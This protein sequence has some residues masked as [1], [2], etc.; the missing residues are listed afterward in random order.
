MFIYYSAII[1][2]AVFS[3]VIMSV[4][5][6]NNNVLTRTE[7]RGFIATFLLVATVAAAEWLG[8]LCDDAANQFR[9]LHIIAKVVEFSIAPMIPVICAGSISSFRRAKYM[10]I[11][12]MV[13]CALEIFSGI[14]GFIFSVDSA[15]VYHRESFYWIY[16]LSFV[17]S[18]IYLFSECFKL[19]RAFQNRNWQILALIILFLVAG[20][21]V[22]LIKSNIR[23][24]WICV[25]ISTILLYIYYSELILQ[26]DALTKLLS[27]RSY[28]INL[29]KIK[30]PVSIVVF[31]VDSFKNINDNFGH[32][33]GDDCLIK[34]SEQIKSIYSKYG[35]CY[36]IGG[37]EFCVILNRRLDENAVEALNAELHKR[38]EKRRKKSGLLPDVSIG[39]AKYDPAK[40]ELED[41]LE[42]AD[43]LMYQNKN[44][45][46]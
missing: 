33:T 36:R 42:K 6:F 38:L 28:E 7:K 30:R 23:I 16:I 34:V 18:L 43:R 14:F 11:P 37:D 35:F 27:R 15:D 46:R 8:V 5:V 22:Q 44:S 17:A 4:I 26:M 29:E 19:S 40:D 12:I 31:D 45:G 9:I 24:D 20:V 32:Q 41:V 25:S 2:L 13:N 10:M 1:A 21:S 3:L 39:Y